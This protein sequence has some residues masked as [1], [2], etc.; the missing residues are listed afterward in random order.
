MSQHYQSQSQSQG[1][2]PLK[3]EKEKEEDRDRRGGFFWWW[4]RP[5]AG[6]A[7]LTAGIYYGGVYLGFFPNTQDL[8]IDI[9]EKKAVENAFIFPVEGK[10]AQGRNAAFDFIILTE[11]YTW[12]KGSTNQVEG[13]TGIVPD[14]ETAQRV[15]NPQIRDALSSSSDLIAVGLA[16]LEGDQAAEEER[17]NQRS[18]TV[19]RWMETI[20]TPDKGIWRL[21]L[22]QYNKTCKTQEDVNTSFQRPLILI[23][24]RSKE[25]GANLQEALADAISGKKN[26]PS[27]DCYSRFDLAQLR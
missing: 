5:L 14:A 13:R 4:F 27:R 6:L 19:T 22:G 24:V 12:V 9:V 11:D 20:A 26:L 21:N 18:Q 10:D 17:A 23:G 3:P 16:S 25:Q 1:Q 15:I 7:A 2:T 8:K